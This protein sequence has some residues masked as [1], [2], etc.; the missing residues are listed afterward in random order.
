[1]API[2]LHGGGGQP[3]SFRPFIAAAQGGRIA[4]VIENGALPDLPAYRDLLLQVGADERVLVDIVVSPDYPLR[5]E[6]LP[7]DASALFV[8]GGHT[9]S[10]HAALCFDLDWLAAFKAHDLIYSGTSAG[11]AI[12]AEEAIVGGWRVER[13]ERVREMIFK[14]AGEGVDLLEVRDGLGLVPFTIDVHAGQQGTL[15]RLIHMID[16]GLATTGWALDEN[17]LLRVEG[18]RHTVTG[19][20][21]AYYVWSKAGGV[22]VAVL[23]PVA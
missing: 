5:P 8:C 20:G 10:V 16:L 12:A 1:M 21:H 18:D 3:A 4:L 2:F 14:G 6:H 15:I 23:E 7:E 22:E 13:D 11:A 19:S 17:T 9:P